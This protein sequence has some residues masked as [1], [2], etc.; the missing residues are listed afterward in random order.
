MIAYKAFRVQT[1]FSDNLLGRKEAELANI[2][3]VTE[4]C[5]PLVFG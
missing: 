4:E 1:K 2:S 5:V 3:G